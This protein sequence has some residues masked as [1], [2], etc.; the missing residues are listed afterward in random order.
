MIGAF[1]VV[2]HWLIFG[3]G[4]NLPTTAETKGALSGLVNSLGSLIHGLF[5]GEGTWTLEAGTLEALPLI[6][7]IVLEG[8]ILLSIASMVL[9]LFFFLRR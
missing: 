7:S 9:K 8:V 5:I 2:F 3:E 4:A 1:Y 6:C